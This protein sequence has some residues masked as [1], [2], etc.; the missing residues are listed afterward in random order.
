MY[1]RQLLLTHDDPG[2]KVVAG[3]LL[4]RAGLLGAIFD[5]EPGQLGEATR[6]LLLAYRTL[7]DQ[8]QVVIPLA[9]L[10]SDPTVLEQMAQLP[11]VV[12]VLR[13]RQTLCPEGERGDRVAFILLEA[14]AFLIQSSADEVDEATAAKLRLAAAEATLRAILLDPSNCLLYTS[15]GLH[16]WCCAKQPSLFAAWSDR[17]SLGQ[18]VY[19]GRTH[20]FHR[21]SCGPKQ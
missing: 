4:V 1:K 17:R 6:R 7:G 8:P 19:D 16:A 21:Y 10:L 14:E 2:A 5:D 18:W 3:E 13:A 9:D 11:D 15:L 12:Q 20:V